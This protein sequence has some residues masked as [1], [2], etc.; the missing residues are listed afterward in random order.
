MFRITPFT[1]WNIIIV[2][3]NLASVLFIIPII[4]WLLNILCSFSIDIH[5]DKLEL[6]PFYLWRI[7]IYI[8][9]SNNILVNYLFKKCY[10]NMFIHSSTYSLRYVCIG[11]PLV[12]TPF[13]LSNCSSIIFNN[14]RLT[15]TF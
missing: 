7:H 5:N 10:R 2:G 4:Y 3:E 11:S 6:A 9:N 15:T 1:D 8:L 14:F 13:N 12:R